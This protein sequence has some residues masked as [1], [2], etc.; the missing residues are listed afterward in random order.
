MSRPVDSPPRTVVN[1]PRIPASR[2]IKG[3]NKRNRD[4]DEEHEAPVPSPL[5]GARP[6]VVQRST[7]PAS[8]VNRPEPSPTA[9]NER[10]KLDPGRLETIKRP[11]VENFEPPRPPTAALSLGQ[12]RTSSGSSLPSR[13][14]P[15]AGP[16]RRTA[17]PTEEAA[18]LNSVLFVKKKAPRP[19]ARST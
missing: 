14:S 10:F 12:G 8:I 11:R 5:P 3:P 18:R 7:L 9:T 13:S 19:A 2:A 1:G 15:S 4:S 16:P 6:H 17:T